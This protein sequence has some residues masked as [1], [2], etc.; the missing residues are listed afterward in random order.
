MKPNTTEAMTQAM[1]DCITA[2]RFEAAVGY[3]PKDDDLDRSN[4]LD[5]GKIAHQHCGWCLGH[6]K[7]RFIC[8]CALRRAPEPKCT[9]TGHYGDLCLLHQF[10]K[11]A[12]VWL[13]CSQPPK[14]P[15]IFRFR[16][17]KH[18]IT[19]DT[20]RCK[21][22]GEH[23]LYDRCENDDAFVRMRREVI[24]DGEYLAEGKNAA[25]EGCTRSHPHEN[26]NAECERKTV[27]ARLA[28]EAARAAPNYSAITHSLCAGFG[29]RK[30]GE[31]EI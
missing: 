17:T 11:P 19:A 26:M 7:P 25:P 5:A 13:P 21:W 31:R 3:P 6:D 10:A 9:C 20:E 16:D 1:N 30:F 28:N 4:C 22:S 12:E 23:W 2:E 15:G 29:I 24:A 8:G 14:E 18:G 27:A